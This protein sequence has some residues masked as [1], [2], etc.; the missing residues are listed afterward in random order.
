MVLNIFSIR[1]NLKKKFDFGSH[2]SLYGYPQVAG[3]LNVDAHSLI[4]P[5]S[6]AHHQK[7]MDPQ[8]ENYIS[9]FYCLQLYFRLLFQCCKKLSSK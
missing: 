7:W 1:P 8:F 9:C 2:L 4:Y 5:L 6:F 3:C